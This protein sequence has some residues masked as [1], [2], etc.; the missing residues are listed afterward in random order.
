MLSLVTLVTVMLQP[1][2]PRSLGR[3]QL[4]QQQVAAAGVVALP[5]SPA[6]AEDT[7][8]ERTIPQATLLRNLATAKPRDV[9]VTGANSGVGL[10]GAKLLTAAGHRVVCAC[11]TQAKADA[12][13]AE[14]A[15]YAASNAQ[16]SGGTAR[17]AT[18]DL[19]SLASVRSFASSMSS[20]NIDTLVLNAGLSRGQGE[21]QIQRT[22]D[23]F[24]E[25]VGVNHLGH[26]L[27]ASLLTPRVAAATGRIVVTASPVHDP[28]S[29]GGNVGNTATLGG[30]SGLASGPSFEMVD[31]GAYDP[32]KAYKDSKLCNMMYMA[33]ASRRLAPLGVTVNAFSPGLIADPKGFFRN[34]N[35]TF[36]TIFNLITRV[37]GVAESNEFGGAA[38]GY[39]AVDEAE[40]R[41]SGAWFDSLPAGRHQLAVHN[42]SEEARILSSQQ[43]LWA[44]STKLVGLDA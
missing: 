8:F 38:L 32:D 2:P 23:G 29:G 35:P 10:A 31:G 3:R 13:A 14:C 6:A 19:A 15:A 40:A 16:R 28:T 20:A 22:A 34:Q 30:L 1:T 44:L 11:R 36:A 33:E 27:L 37:V 17:G 4:L 12:A 7:V 39:L 26:F 25:T 41:V 21:V 43:R 5:L 24:E 9:V 42:P 18:C